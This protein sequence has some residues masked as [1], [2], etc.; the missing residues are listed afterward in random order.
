MRLKC[1]ILFSALLACALAASEAW[2]DVKIDEANFPD[3]AFRQ[4]LKTKVANGGDVLTDAQIAATEELEPVA[5]EIASLQG[6]EHFTALK[7]LRC[8]GNSLQALDI[9]KNKELRELDCSCSELKSLDVSHNT[10]LEALNCYANALT[11]LNI[12]SNLALKWLKCSNN[13]LTSL[14]VSKNVALETLLCDDNKIETLDLSKNKELLCL[15]CFDNPLKTVNLTNNWNMYKF[16]LP[17]QGAVT[18]PGGDTLS[19]K[20]FSFEAV[21][22]K[23]FRLDLS[24]FGD[25]I[26]DAYALYD[27]S[28]QPA[29]AQA[30][31]Q[32]GV[33]VFSAG[34][35]VRVAYRIGKEGDTIELEFD[36]PDVPGE[37]DL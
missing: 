2:A 21:G 29:Q 27:R 35:Q 15:E 24:K 20:D 11:S 10:K 19:N 26:E 17:K 13:A 32:N 25:K 18:L 16:A 14:D 34:A 28:T 8:A 4:W 6:L 22:E 5:E 36:V 33:H 7:R 1:T 30:Q 12:S 31:A 23:S 37:E 3:A 9:S